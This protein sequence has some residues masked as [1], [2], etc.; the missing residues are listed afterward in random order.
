MKGNGGTIC[1]TE[2]AK[3][4]GLIRAVMKV[5]TLTERNKD[6]AATPGT[7]EVS[8]QESGRPTK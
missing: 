5:S 3:K 2:K 4:L 6:W 1:S 7:M 8:T